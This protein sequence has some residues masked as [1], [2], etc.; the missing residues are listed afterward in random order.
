MSFQASSRFVQTAA[1]INN[2]PGEKF[3]LLLE[4]I[5]KKLHLKNVRLLSEEEEESLRELFGF[6]PNELKMVLDCLCYTFEQAA[7]TSTGPEALFEVL[8]NAGF[9]D[10]H[11]KILAK[12]WAAEASE[13]VNKLKNQRLGYSSLE[14]IDYHLN[15]VVGQDD[16][17]RQQE[18]LSIFEFGINATPDRSDSKSKN[19]EKVCVEFNH[20]ELYDFFSQLERMQQQLDALGKN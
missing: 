9:D 8:Q 15:M 2:I 20:S 5:L 11:A 4:R 6:N 7:F 10:I 13:Y 19:Q 3:P 16:L 18:P 17:T 14:S 1:I 12:I